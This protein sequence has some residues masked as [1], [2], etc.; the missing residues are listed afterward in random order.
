MTGSI[1]PQIHLDFYEITSKYMVTDIIY[2]T[3]NQWEYEQLSEEDDFIIQKVADILKDE[4][5]ALRYAMEALTYA[6]EK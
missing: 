4:P 5:E 1:D 6:R 2:E 3:K